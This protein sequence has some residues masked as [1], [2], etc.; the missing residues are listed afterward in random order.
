ME[1]EIK[2][3]LMDAK[4]EYFNRE[5]SL[6]AE[7]M[8]GGTLSRVLETAYRLTNS[9]DKAWY[10]GGEDIWVDEKAKKGCRST[11]VG[12]LIVIHSDIYIVM[13]VGF[14]YLC[15]SLEGRA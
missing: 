11:S 3:W 6:V 8:V 7:V 9:S 10:K 12:D 4:E 1:D 14:T 5:Y 13:P 2:S 15:G